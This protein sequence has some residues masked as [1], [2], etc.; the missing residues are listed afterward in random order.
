MKSNLPCPGKSKWTN[1]SSD[2]DGSKGNEAAECSEKPSSSACSSETERSIPRSFRMALKT[3]FK[4]S[5]EERCPWESVYS[6][7]WR[8]YNGLVEVGYGKHLLP[9][10]EGMRIPVQSSGS[11]SLS[12]D[13][14]NDPE[15]TSV[16]VI[17][18]FILNCRIE[19]WGGGSFDIGGHAGA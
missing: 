11:G 19:K 5:F 3:L 4:A 8:G 7:G 16:I 2:P 17:A 10:P 15:K 6:D 14:E 13:P 9:S 12:I 18:L 1:P